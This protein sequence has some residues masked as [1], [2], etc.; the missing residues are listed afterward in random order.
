VSPDRTR[1]L[2]LDRLERH[3]RLTLHAGD[4]TRLVTLTES[5][6]AV[7]VHGD[8][9]ADGRIAIVESGTSARLR[10]TSPDGTGERIVELA[11]GP[12]GVRLGA[13]AAPGQL[14]V[15]LE[16]RQRQQRE[17]VLV[18]LDGA[19]VLQRY[20]DLSPAATPWFPWGDAG[21]RPAPGSPATRLFLDV[22]GEAFSLDLATGAR[23][24]AFARAP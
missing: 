2:V 22:S 6:T 18:D 23:R 5:G 24:P 19:R 17:T 21:A 16:Y 13:E 11:A 14:T 12:V 8:F 7:N 1:L 10:L 15:G 4:G 3:A 20:P 9:L